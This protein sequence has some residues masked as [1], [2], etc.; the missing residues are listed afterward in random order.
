MRA[1]YFLSGERPG[2][3]LQPTEIVHEV[4]LRMKSVSPEALQNR[5][6]FLAFAGKV[7]RNLLV[8]YARSRNAERHGGNYARVD[9]PDEM[10][11]SD[12]NVVLILQVDELIKTLSVI[13]K[14]AATVVEMRFFAGLNEEEIAEA[15]DVSVRTVK[16]D[17]GFAKA[18]MRAQL[19]ESASEG[20]E[21]A[22]GSC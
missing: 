21:A 8:D 16:R 11:F 19:S 10:L 12:N 18:W 9:L 15:L 14:R 5:D 7:M 22:P 17:W 13:D 1:Q 4:W 2:H 3:T 20:G 6:A